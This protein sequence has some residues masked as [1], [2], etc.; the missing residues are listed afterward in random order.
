MVEQILKNPDVGILPKLLSAPVIA[1]IYAGAFG[2]VFWLD[3]VYAL[4]VAM[5]IP[6]L[7]TIW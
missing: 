3:L 2:S 6:N 5:L 4:A 1:L 7:L